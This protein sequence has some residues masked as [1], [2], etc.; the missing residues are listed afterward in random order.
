MNLNKTK[1]MNSNVIAFVNN[2][3]IEKTNAYIY[4][5]HE[6]KLRK[7]NAMAKIGLE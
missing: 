4:L 2:D 6:I 7:E 5:G 1:I 3:I